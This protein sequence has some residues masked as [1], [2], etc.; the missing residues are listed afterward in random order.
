MFVSDASHARLW[1][2]WCY[3]R[4]PCQIGWSSWLPPT[5]SSAVWLPLRA[6]V[7]SRR[8]RACMLWPLSS[9][10]LSSRQWAVTASGRQSSSVS[11]PVVDCRHNTGQALNKNVITLLKTREVS[12][13]YAKHERDIAFS[14]TYSSVWMSMTPADEWRWLA[15]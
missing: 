8:R 13:F 5:G 4:S 10:F 6:I 9:Y 14:H 12:L 7:I 3:F 1:S 15:K 11:A 2:F